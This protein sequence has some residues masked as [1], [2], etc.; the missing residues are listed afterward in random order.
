MAEA[1]LSDEE[2]EPSQKNNEL[3]NNGDSTGAKADKATKLDCD[4][5][6]SRKSRL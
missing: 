3:S 1:N 4:S 6:D 5:D 2:R